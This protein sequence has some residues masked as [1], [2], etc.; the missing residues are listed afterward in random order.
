MRKQFR[1]PA[2]KIACLL[3]FYTVMAVKNSLDKVFVCG[4]RSGLL[5]LVLKSANIVLMPISGCMFLST[6]L[7]H[8]VMHPTFVPFLALWA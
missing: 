1:L 8:G 3:Q 4:L 7:V 6:E 5:V 2:L